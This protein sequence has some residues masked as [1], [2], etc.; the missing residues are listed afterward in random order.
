MRQTGSAGTPT[1]AGARQATH[2]GRGGGFFKPNIPTTIPTRTFDP[3]SLEEE[4]ERSYPS[5]LAASARLSAPS[6]TLSRKAAV[7]PARFSAKKRQ[8][9][10]RSGAFD[11]TA[12]RPR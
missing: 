9:A 7:S 6:T 11:A 5:A 4:V 2:P 10:M 3:T 12:P 8:S 1:A